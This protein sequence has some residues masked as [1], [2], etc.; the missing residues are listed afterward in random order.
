[1][2]NAD[3]SWNWS[4]LCTPA[5][6]LP[7]QDC[8][9]TSIDEAPWTM[10]SLGVKMPKNFSTF[11]DYFDD[12]CM[13]RRSIPDSSVRLNKHASPSYQHDPA[14]RIFTVM[15]ISISDFNDNEP[16]D[17]ELVIADLLTYTSLIFFS[18]E[19]QSTASFSFS[20][21][22]LES[23]KGKWPNSFSTSSSLYTTV[24][25]AALS[26]SISSERPNRYELN[27]WML[28]WRRTVF[29]THELTEIPPE[30]PP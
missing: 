4:A 19:P 25:V 15:V 20:C 14:W 16:L 12:V 5:H 7:S 21:L 1:M 13:S 10:A 29:Q 6:A 9:L 30:T 2:D 18:T 17:L 28:G 24:T 3:L 22:L 8:I 11:S 23:L 26:I 27:P